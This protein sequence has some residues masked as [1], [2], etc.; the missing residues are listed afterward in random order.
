MKKISLFKSYFRTELFV[1]FYNEF[2]KN[3]SSFTHRDFKCDDVLKN[4]SNIFHYRYRNKKKTIDFSTTINTRKHFSHGHIYIC[5]SFLASKS[6]WSVC[7]A[8]KQ[9]NS[10]KKIMSIIDLKILRQTNEQ[11][12]IE[13]PV[14]PYFFSCS[15]SFNKKKNYI[16]D[17]YDWFDQEQIHRVYQ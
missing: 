14:Y 13:I 3:W 16:F 6:I 7:P 2:K 1:S 17:F 12:P 15:T 10:K 5:S 4:N 9:T 8:N 11:N